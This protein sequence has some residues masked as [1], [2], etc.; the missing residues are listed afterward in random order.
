MDQENKNQSVEEHIEEEEEGIELL[1]Q[2]AKV[3][4]ARK[5]AI[6]ML[7]WVLGI[8]IVAGVGFLVALYTL[9]I[10]ARQTNQ[11]LQ[12]QL[13][14]E[15]Q[16][17]AV[18]EAQIED[19]RL[20]ESQHR[21]A[22]A[23]LDEAKLRRSILSARVDVAN[24]Q[25]ALEKQE[26]ENAKLA[27]SQT[28]QTLSEI[29]GL[30]PAAQAQLVEEMQARLDLALSGIDGNAYAAASDLDVLA[31]SLLVLENTVFNRGT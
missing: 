13:Q 7:R 27:L 5:A 8:L 17:Y 19:W 18:L 4:R 25:L 2:P 22:L 31:T 11:D 23:E 24:A 1:Q 14:Q 20:L 16:K 9:F 10:P 28:S 29:K 6:S 3:S 26:A 12:Q 21:E 30:V 15:K